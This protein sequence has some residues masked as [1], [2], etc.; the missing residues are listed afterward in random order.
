MRFEVSQVMD[1]IERRLSTDIVMAQAV[2]DLGE[3]TRYAD[4]DGGRSVNLIRVG[5]VVDAFG[6]YL[7]DGGAMIYPVTPRQLLSE[8]ALTAKERMVLGRWTDGGLIEAA[9]DGAERVLEIAELTGLPIITL[10]DHADR[11]KRYDWLRD[12]PLRVLTVSPRGG[13]ALLTDGKGGTGGVPP[14]VAKSAPAGDTVLRRVD[15][16]P[17]RIW[18]DPTEPVYEPLP[19][20]PAYL[21]APSPA[22]TALIARAWR[23][24]GFDC[25]SFG[26]GR[27]LGQPVPRL[28]A[29]K[30]VCPRHDEPLREIGPRPASVP[31]TLVIDGLRRRHFVVMADRPLF[32]GRAP[33]EPDAIGVGEWLHEAAARWIS[34]THLKLEISDNRLVATDLSRNGTLVW[35]RSEPGDRPDTYRLARGRSYPL[36]EWDTIEM[37]TGIELCRADRRPEGVDESHDEPSSVLTDAPTFAMRQLSTNG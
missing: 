29:G 14:V 15:D 22:G 30:P 5:M 27:R 33:E 31:V 8:A 34:R 35:V 1:T 19:E 32:V 2:V 28:R 10:R 16:E 18:P 9:R 21:P 6:R 12:A 23:C 20:P 4:L 36:G 13:G 3:I 7:R 26:E 25:P 37:Y 24:D 11:G 17:P